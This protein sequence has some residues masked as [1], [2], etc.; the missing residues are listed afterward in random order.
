MRHKTQQNPPAQ[1]ELS[2]ELTG[3]SNFCSADSS[4]VRQALY[5]VIKDSCVGV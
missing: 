5:W 1:G 4:R 3:L 2:A